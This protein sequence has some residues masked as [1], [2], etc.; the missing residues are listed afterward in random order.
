MPL[1]IRSLKLYMKTSCEVPTIIGKPLYRQIERQGGAYTPQI[2]SQQE[3]TA[4]L[5]QD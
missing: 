1:I 2:V 4:I 5:V 3:L